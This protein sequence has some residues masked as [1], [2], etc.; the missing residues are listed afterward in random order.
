[1]SQNNQNNYFQAILITMA[2]FTILAVVAALILVVR[3]LAK[4][5]LFARDVPG[6]LIARFT[7]FWYLFQ[8]STG[9]FHLRNIELH[10]K[11]GQWS[12]FPSMLATC[13]YVAGPV[14]RIAPNEFSISDPKAIDTI[15]GHGKKFRK[16]NV[17]DVVWLPNV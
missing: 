6:P 9:K 1:L 3:S 13:S 5:L 12:L 2:S 16:V 7:R 4:S 14:V 17:P 11:Y 15:Y 8:Q 10:Q